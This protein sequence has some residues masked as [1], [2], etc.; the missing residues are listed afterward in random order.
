MTNVFLV[1]GVSGAGKTTLCKHLSFSDGRIDHFSI[2]DFLKKLLGN[3]SHVYY[4]EVVRAILE[5][6]IKFRA[7]V[8]LVDSGDF[9]LRDRNLMRQPSKYFWEALNPKGLITVTADPRLILERRVIDRTKNRGKRIADSISTIELEQR[10]VISGAINVA[11]RIS[12]SFNLILNEGS[13]KEGV[14]ALK[15][16]IILTLREHRITR[17]LGKE[18]LL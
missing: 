18:G 13:V 16:S 14:A 12:A 17:L 3:R 2:G 1:V 8:L 6:M 5:E 11:N 10:I 15:K 7:D 4:L 9:I